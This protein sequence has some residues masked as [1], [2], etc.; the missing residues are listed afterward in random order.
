MQVCVLSNYFTISDWGTLRGKVDESGAGAAAP[1]PGASGLCDRTVWFFF[2]FSA[3]WS[4]VIICLEREQILWSSWGLLTRVIFT[5]QFGSRG[6]DNDYEHMY[7]SK[8]LFTCCPL[9][10]I[11]SGSEA[12]W[13]L[14]DC[15]SSQWIIALAEPITSTDKS[16]KISVDLPFSYNKTK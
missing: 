7:Y 14:R 8:R 15:P 2:F 10:H 11:Y 9:P 5:V 4:S 13:R 6:K 16:Q 3:R 12:V 1:L